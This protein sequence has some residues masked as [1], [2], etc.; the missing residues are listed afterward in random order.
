MVPQASYQFLMVAKKNKK[1]KYNFTNQQCQVLTDDEPKDV[2]NVPDL[3][4]Q[5]CIRPRCFGERHLLKEPEHSCQDVG[6]RDSW[7]HR[8]SQTQ[9]LSVSPQCPGPWAVLPLSAAILLWLSTGSLQPLPGNNLNRSKYQSRPR[10]DLLSSIYQFCCLLGL[11]TLLTFYPRCP[12]P[13]PPP[14]S[15]TEHR[16]PRAEGAARGLKPQRALRASA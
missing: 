16:V 8:L 11:I 6:H 1:I 12:S 15:V 5:I 4:Y 10:G 9:R 2:T 7:P 13:P 14:Q 3:L